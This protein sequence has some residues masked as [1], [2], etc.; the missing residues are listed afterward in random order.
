MSVIGSRYQIEK[1]LG[2]GGMGV[3]YHATD[4]RTGQ[5][6]AIKQLRREVAQRRPDMVERFAREAEALRQLDHPNMVKAF[7]TLEYNDE[8]Y[9]V[10]E[11]VEG[12]TLH[13]ILTDDGPLPITRV[14]QISIELADALTRAHY[15]EIIHR[16][17][18]PA[19]VMIETAGTSRLTDFGVAYLQNRDRVTHNRLQIGTPDYMSPEAIEGKSVD[20]RADIWSLGI[21]MWEM[22]TGAHPWQA[23]ALPAMLNNIFSK[24]LPDLEEIRPDVPVALVDLIYRMLEK[25]RAARIPSVRLVGV[26]LEII[27][28]SLR[29]GG[30][31]ETPA[32]AEVRRRAASSTRF[33]TPP[34]TLETIHNNL[35]APTTGFVGRA[36][37]LGELY[38]L[39][40]DADTRIITVLGP[41]GMGKTRLML[42]L[43]RVVV[44]GRVPGTQARRYE[45]EFGHGVY[46]ASM[47]AHRSADAVANALAEAVG[48]RFYPGTPAV[49][50]LIDYLRD[51]ALLLLVDNCEHLAGELNLL[52]DIL[53]AAPH[54]K[55]I[56][57]SRVRLGLQGETQFSIDGMDFPYNGDGDDA[58]RYGAVQLF[59]QSARRVQ[60]RFELQADDITHITRICR[61][62][63]GMP[64]GI[65]LAAGW[66]EVLSPREIADEVER[67]FDFLEANTVSAGRQR[68]MRAV[69]ESSWA[70][71]T[72][73]ERITFMRIAVFRGPFTRTAGQTVTGAGLRPLMGL[74]S[75]SFLQR[76]PDSGRYHAH[77][78]MRQFAEERLIES[79]GAGQVYAA[80]GAYFLTMV[81]EALPAVQSARQAEAF[82][83]FDYDFENIRTALLW[84]AQHGHNALLRPALH[85]LC[86][87]FDLRAL[88]NEGLALLQSVMAILR[89][90]PAAPERDDVLASLS[91][92]AGFY[93]AYFRQ[94]DLALPYIE[95]ALAL[96]RADSPPEV[97]AQAQLACGYYHMLLDDVLMARE[98]FRRAAQIFGRMGR[99]WDVAH[100]RM[101]WGTAFCYRNSAAQLDYDMARR[102]THEAL[103]LTQQIGENHLEAYCYFSLGW[104]DSL[105]HDYDAAA[106]NIHRAIPLFRA[107]RNMFAYGN[108][109]QTLAIND[110]VRGR[111]DEARALIRENIAINRQRGH[112]FYIAQGLLVEAR[113]ELWAGNWAESRDLAEEALH[114]AGGIGDLQ[115]AHTARVA[116]ARVDAVALE[117]PA[118]KETLLEAL[119]IA[120]QHDRLMDASSAHH[121]LSLVYYCLHD[122]EMGYA[123]A[124]EALALAEQAGSPSHVATA[125]FG[126]ARLAYY[127]KDHALAQP[128]FEAALAFLTDDSA[129]QSVNGWDD[130]YRYQMLYSVLADYAGTE[131]AAGHVT[132]ARELL[133]RALSVAEMWNNIPGQLDGITM[134]CE[135][136]LALDEPEQAAR[137]AVFVREQPR[138]Y[139]FNRGTASTFLRGLRQSGR[140]PDF[141]RIV[142]EP[143]TLQLPVVV[144]NI[145]RRL[146]SA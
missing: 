19:N 73:E 123:S 6:V 111:L 113:I 99:D 137:L 128:H 74:V 53:H 115:S 146:Q 2:R 15:L 109:L 81:T 18:K 33:E 86:I 105:Q 66:A 126:I 124:Y 79:G 34:P 92:W 7:D 22:L 87:Y 39:L 95:D 141:D 91:S 35:G 65:E 121:E 94:K 110:I 59:I 9:I 52:S 144:R 55:I 48:F 96:A 101:N 28:N 40:H 88:Y 130:G 11:Y 25:D 89:T 139:A 132:Q 145:L 62:V 24:P 42:E 49:E 16:D 70:L 54:V 114:L 83:A 84:M 45:T 3:V 46:L 133:Y 57:T 117:Y 12:R 50:Q 106:E 104:I 118:A 112:Q 13:D 108:A 85:P 63:G 23:K 1:L 143:S 64:L 38:R 14:A 17:I 138:A 72:P 32:M 5:A 127:L 122:S 129:Q 61:R 90:Q 10:M 82:T 58:L 102:L 134:A 41:G 142:N 75:K 116:I 37:E 80:H 93:A 76:D 68:S 4:M 135:L 78:L 119:D 77:E 20:V 27:L 97:Q 71:L 43:G 21:V 136:L 107:A 8:R 120:R 26:E 69:F 47:Q 125:H 60:P 131:L 30:T 31:G 103:H 29:R 100:I 51:K 67:S 140:L 98:A 36:T 56:T 44:E